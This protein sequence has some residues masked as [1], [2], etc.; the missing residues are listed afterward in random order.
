M[1]NAK[2]IN[3]I[4]SIPLSTIYYNLKKLEKIG[5][6][7]HIGGNGRPSKITGHASRALAQYVRRDSTLSKKA[8]AK[9][10]TD[11]GVEV[12]PTTIGRHLT[13]GG[14]KKSLPKAIPMLTEA[15]RQKR[16]KWAKEHLNDNWDR[17]LFS[18]ETAFQLSQNTIKRWHKGLRPI[19][20]IPK[21][22]SKIFAWGGFCKKG[23]TN[24]FC[25]R[26]IMN[27]EF[28]VNILHNHIPE[29]KQMLGSRWRFQQDN[30][31]KHT[32]GFTKAFLKENVPEVLNWPSN[33]PDLNPIENLWAIVKGNVEK[34][35]PKNLRELEAFMQ[36]EWEK[37]HQSSLIKLVDSMRRRC[38]LVIEANGEH[39]PY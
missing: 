6:V 33:S 18:D 24:L 34:R 11:I 28:Y 38:T 21:V 22:R 1:R 23:K 12:S 8:L 3:E 29:V 15:Q 7:E 10:L 25:F 16:V 32:S 13:K 5:T 27:S 26:Q 4:T 35:M 31:P 14:Y 30:D 36:E 39:I 2:E 17:T 19:R 9:K 37:I 20:P